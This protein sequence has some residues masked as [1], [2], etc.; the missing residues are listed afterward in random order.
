MLVAL[1]GV[2]GCGKSSVATALAEL[3]GAEVLAFPNDD[4]VTGPM[5][6]AYLRREWWLDGTGR[7]D[8][9][10]NDPEMAQ[11]GAL[12]FQ[13]LQTV[14]RL[15]SE[16]MLGNASLGE[17]E[18]PRVILARYWQ[19][20]WVYGGLDGLDRDWLYRLHATMPQPHMNILLDVTTDTAMKRRRVRDGHAVR[21]RYEGRRKF[22]DKVVCSYRALWHAH[23][24]S[25]E[26]CVVDAGQPFQQVVDACA[27]LIA[28][29]FEESEA[30]GEV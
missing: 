17:S 27:A 5:I 3:L 20:G 23:L 25:R 13:A 19:S 18:G 22:V 15:E 16:P 6:R 24:A 12:A 1:E 29:I 11:A 4:S 21:E 2:D 30:N 8:F 14:N 10:R 28:G 9:A 26:W 7:T